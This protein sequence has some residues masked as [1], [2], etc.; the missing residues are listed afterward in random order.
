ML[1]RTKN[2]DDPALPEDGATLSAP[3]PVAAPV[4]AA[5]APKRR[6][7]T[8]PVLMLGGIAIVAVGAGYMWL[9]GGRYVSTD[10]AYIRAAKLMVSTDV[11]GIVSDVDV[12]EGQTVAAGDVLFRVDPQQYE[13]GVRNAQANLDET[14][15][16][17]EGRK[18][19]YK[20][21]MSDIAAA[22]ATVQNDQATFDR[23]QQLVKDTAALSRA[24]YDQGRYTLEAD[25]GKLQSLKQQA[26]SELAK[27]GGD[28]NF[29]VEQHP[30]YLQAKAALD[31]A[32][33]QL[34][35]AIVRAPFAGTVTAV[36]SLQPGLYLVAA[37]AGLSN[38][39][40]IGLIANDKVWIDAH[41]KET[42]L[43]YVK[44]GDA[45]DVSVDAY[46]G[47]TWRGTVDSIAPASG[48][49]FS[50]LPA[51]N[52]SGNWVKVVQRVPV[53]VLVQQAATDP[54]LRSGMSVNVDIDTGH[55]RKL[56]EIF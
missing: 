47:Q 46:P 31:E 12:K 43:T 17:L 39:G 9:T 15:L 36:D 19:D 38:Q 27:L 33:R 23:Y 8:R 2:P 13:I 25:Q 54:Q 44:P 26:A 52:A 6:S 51:Q 22:Q 41:V 20:R 49:E 35:H 37:T 30:L 55:K 29:N 21:M 42:D 16:D 45:V 56:S 11:S 53:R 18:I 14:R 34:D 1:D 28:A 5:P 32:R 10:D 40:A 48:A 7:Y 24:T 4:V 50:I 3:A